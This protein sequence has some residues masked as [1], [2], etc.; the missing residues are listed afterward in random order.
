MIPT[1]A[2]KG[3]SW[4]WRFRG[5]LTGEDDGLNTRSARFTT[6]RKHE[7]RR[8]AAPPSSAMPRRGKTTGN[9]TETNTQNRSKRAHGA[10]SIPHRVWA[11][12]LAAAYPPS[13]G[14]PEPTER[15]RNEQGTAAAS[16]SS[17]N[18]GDKTPTW[19]RWQ[20]SLP[21]RGV[22][23]VSPVPT[24]KHVARRRKRRQKQNSRPYPNVAQGVRV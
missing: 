21:K 22:R 24:D 1:F 4:R 5:R 20:S 11:N 19:R 2:N 13:G 10:L 23:E 6:R 8:K 16:T 17:T 12:N 7:I 9:T 14:A 15:P 18:Y 3:A